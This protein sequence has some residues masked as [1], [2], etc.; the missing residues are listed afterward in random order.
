[1]ISSDFLVYI[2]EDDHDVLRSSSNLVTAAGYQV[3]TYTSGC[4][5]LAAVTSAKERPA[6]LITDYQ[7]GGLT[8][9]D[10]QKSLNERGINI[11]I[12]FVSG[13]AGVGVAVEAMRQGAITLLEKPFSPTDLLKSI[14]EAR[15]IMEAQQAEQAEADDA[16]RLL[17]SLTD[18]E[19]EVL[20]M[21]IEGYANKV[22]AYR[23]GI[24]LRTVERRR[25]E[26]FAKTNVTTEVQLAE[27]VNLAGWEKP[28]QPPTREQH[29]H[30]HAVRLPR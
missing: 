11:P 7:M 14:E 1:M 28:E 15:S 23:L 25:H 12:V 5:F 29:T 13:H 10:V 22:V 20:W 21:M 24:S 19:K 4:D 2:V 16:R 9:L 30:E 6:C 27:L 17:D 18:K 3:E 26:I 8:G